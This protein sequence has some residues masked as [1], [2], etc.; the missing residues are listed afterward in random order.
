MILFNIVL[1]EPEIPSNT[2]NIARTCA[3]T[4][5]TL[6]LIEP[7]GFKIDD[8]SLK[9][10]GLDYWDSLNVRVYKNWDM[11]LLEQ[12]GK[13]MYFSTTKAQ[14]RYSDFSYQPG[15]FFIFGKET[16]GI[17]KEIL[18][19]NKETLI[20]IPMLAGKRSL[21]LSNSVNI[22]IYEALRQMDFGEMV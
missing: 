12:Q 4:G 15:A 1:H 5:C 19:Q 10:A 3:I 20:K 18:E 17:P 11:F 14:K 2:G 16:A 22:V 9:R 6:H 7:L 13:P 21:N 8:K